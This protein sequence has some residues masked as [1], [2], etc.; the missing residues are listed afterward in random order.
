MNLFDQLVNEAI[1]QSKNL[2]SLKVVV[3]KELL[4][5]DI[6]REMSR[7]GLLEQLTFMG[8]TCLRACYES[9]RLSEDLDF[10]GGHNFNKS[11]LSQLADVLQSQLQNKYGL[12]IG[13]VEPKRETGN[14][15]TWK[16]KVITRPEQRSMPTQ[17][18][19][20]DICSIPSYDKKTSVLR[21]HYGVDMGTGNLLLQIESREEIFADKIVAFAL[22]PNRIKSR[23]LW[24]IVWLTQQGIKLPIELV[25]KKIQDHKQKPSEFTEKLQERKND[26]NTSTSLE[27]TFQQ[28]MRR[29]LPP[30]I[31][32]NS[33]DSDGFWDYMKQVVSDACDS[34]G[35]KQNNT[36]TL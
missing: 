35:K 18:I 31:V 16:L 36:Y 26:L 19:N 10:T 22:R 2:G 13:V 12:Q 23:D 30:D 34:V 6:I 24:D 29:F 7:A 28:E 1:Q 14:V 3:E 21:N 9:N 20:I 25:T 27:E 5:H 15:D 4:H 8:G 32:K 11:S 17:R 33:I